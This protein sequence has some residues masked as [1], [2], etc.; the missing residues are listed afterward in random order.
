MRATRVDAGGT[1]DV[2]AGPGG[3]Q[4]ATLY[5]IP[6]SHACRTAM[7]ALAHKGIVYRPV[8]L[9]SG[10][11]PVIVRMLGFPGSPGG[12]RSLDGARSPMLA[13]MD[14]LGTVPALRLGGRRVQT[15]RAIIRHLEE[16]RP[17]PALYPA[18]PAL[19]LQVEEAER[20]GDEVLQM[21]ARRIALA[22]SLRGLDELHARGAHGRLGALLSHG[23]TMRLL[24]S[25]AS[26]RTTFA[27]GADAERDLL[28]GLPAMLDRVDS[29]IDA[30]VLDRQAVNA[31]DLMI[32]PSLALLA[33]RRDLSGEVLSRPCGAMMERLLPDG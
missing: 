29:W 17:E 5:V 15:N 13:A 22:A 1:S 12:M 19:R 23:D 10:L 21:A 14:R 3:E 8:E 6:G 2:R 7:L 25:R 24:M 9:P 26:A 16:L 28:I 31:A 20:W 18:D 33:Y 27:A 32:A 11:H 30:G 4:T